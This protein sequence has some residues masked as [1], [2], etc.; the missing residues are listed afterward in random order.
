MASINDY[1]NLITSEHADR[2][3]FVATVALRCQPYVD[4]INFYQSVTSAYDLD[5]AIGAQLD[6]VGQ[7]VGISRYLPVPLVGVYFTLD[8][9]PGLDSG[10]LW[11]GV[12]PL[13]GL[14]A[15]P[16]LY[17]RILLRAKILN[18]QWD[19]SLP[20]AYAIGQSIFTEFGY[21]LF[22]Q[23]NGNLTMNLGIHG[24]DVPPITI[25]A[26]LINH[27]LDIKPATIQLTEYIWQAVPGPIFML[28][29]PAG[30]THFAGLDSGQLALVTQ[31]Y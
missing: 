30:S 12:S 3:N 24:P 2:P 25:Q 11:D 19:G 14:V 5:T 27:L 20:M 31:N 8:T 28:D 15:L 1:I 17:Y 18:N 9:G 26:M 23:D 29:A 21:T 4:L 7:W 13:T 22:I 6:V 10:I 16:D